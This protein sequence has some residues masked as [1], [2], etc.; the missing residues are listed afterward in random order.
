MNHMQ[1]SADCNMLQEK[2]VN[3]YVLLKPLAREGQ[4]S[5]EKELKTS[6]SRLAEQF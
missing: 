1:V 6:Q 5:N 2:A 4:P 3:L